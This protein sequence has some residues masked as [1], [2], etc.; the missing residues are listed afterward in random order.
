MAALTSRAPQGAKE[1]AP[2]GTSK[3]LRFGPDHAKES[4]MRRLIILVSVVLAMGVGASAYAGDYHSGAALVCTDCHA[5]HASQAH[6]YSGSGTVFPPVS[7]SGPFPNLLREEETKM[8]LACHDGQAFAPDVFGSSATNTR[9]QAGGLNAKAGTIANDVGY[10]E[11][12]EI[13]RAHV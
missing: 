5:A 13:G 12:D 3:E 9:R 6:T 10:D 7:A 11:I 2:M 1:V 8:C 4:I